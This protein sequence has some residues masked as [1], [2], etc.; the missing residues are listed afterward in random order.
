LFTCVFPFSF[1]DGNMGLSKLRIKIVLL[2]STRPTILALK[3][4]N[5]LH[6]IQ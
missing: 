2:N 5:G 1:V 3:N 4:G 6:I